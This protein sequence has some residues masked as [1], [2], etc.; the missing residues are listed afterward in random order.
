LFPQPPPLSLR[1]HSARSPTPSQLPLTPVYTPAATPTGET[2]FQSSPSRHVRKPSPPTSIL[3][4]SSS[5]CSP[6]PSPPITPRASS[7]ISRNSSRGSLRMISPEP[8]APTLHIRNSSPHIASVKVHNAHRPTSSDSCSAYPVVSEH[9]NY[10]HRKQVALSR[11]NVSTLLEAYQ[12]ETQDD[13]KSPS[14]EQ[15]TQKIQWGYAV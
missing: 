2:S 3:K 11:T 1:N 15:N 6:L 10:D 13:I 7:I 8:F 4:K 5:Y 12:P 9:M 14:A